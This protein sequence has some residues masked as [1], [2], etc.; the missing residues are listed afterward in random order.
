MNT[1]KPQRFCEYFIYF[2]IHANDS[3]YIYPVLHVRRV[4]IFCH[5]PI[6]LFH[7]K[8]FFLESVLKHQDYKQATSA[9]IE[10]VLREWFRTAR[11]RDGG[12]RKRDVGDDNSSHS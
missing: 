2:Q 3:Q 5:L 7:L 1:P 4:N 8:I 6:I 12:R 10:K 11:D 9:E